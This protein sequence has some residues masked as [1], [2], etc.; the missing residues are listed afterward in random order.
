[1]GFKIIISHDS[2]I[3]CNL[4]NHN[5]L[6]PRNPKFYQGWGDSLQLDIELRQVLGI[7]QS[8]VGWLLF[9]S[10]T[11]ID[12]LQF[13]PERARDSL[14]HSA[15]ATYSPLRRWGGVPG[16][17]MAPLTHHHCPFKY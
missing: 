5:A 8:R 4:Y 13:V 17:G 12:W 6:S 10:G 1:M 2:A 16:D 15:K 7:D 14:R 3:S 9:C 11:A